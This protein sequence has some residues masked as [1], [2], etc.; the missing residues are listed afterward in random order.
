MRALPGPGDPENGEKGPGSP[1]PLPFFQSLLQR[2]KKG[3]LAKV[4]VRLA[5]LGASGGYKQ[6]ENYDQRSDATSTSNDIRSTQF[7]WTDP[8]SRIEFPVL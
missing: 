7:L 6:A 8:E 3:A 4:A 5:T 2:I 1:L